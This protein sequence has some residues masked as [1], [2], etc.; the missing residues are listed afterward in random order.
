MNIKEKEYW[1]NRYT[2][3]NTGWDI[4]YPSTPIKNY[5]DQLENKDIKVLIP[6]AGNAYEAEYI[7]NMGF[8]NVFVLD[9]SVHLYGTWEYST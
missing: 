7:Y 8:K 1:T 2:E 9:I 5:I 4:G 3:Q 6:G